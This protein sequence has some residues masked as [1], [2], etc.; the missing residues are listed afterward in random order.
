[1]KRY[2]LK[3]ELKQHVDTVLPVCGGSWR[4]GYLLVQE[5]VLLHGAEA[6]RDS[7]QLH[8]LVLLPGKV[9]EEHHLAAL[10]LHLSGAARRRRYCATVLFL[11][12]T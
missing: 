1:M 4:V 7:E 9:G 12:E 11:E 10:P 6:A 5:E 2:V 3:E 8:L